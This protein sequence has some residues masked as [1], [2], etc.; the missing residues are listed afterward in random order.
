MSAYFI[1]LINI[2]DAGRYQEYLDG[3]DEVFAKHRGEVVAVDDQPRVLEGDW[4]AGRTV[5]IRFSNEQMLRSWYESSD[6]QH[7]IEHRQAASTG[8]IAI[9][10]GR[11]SV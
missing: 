1:A 5:L 4:P 3:F 11:E 8:S 7:L 6:Y 10:T 9:V 2:H